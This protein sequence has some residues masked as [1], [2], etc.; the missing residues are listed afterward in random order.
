M[1]GLTAEEI[2]TTDLEVMW[3]EVIA[4]LRRHHCSDEDLACFLDEVPSVPGA[5]KLFMAAD[6]LEWLGY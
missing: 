3:A 6:V 1:R 5:P 2:Y 4:E